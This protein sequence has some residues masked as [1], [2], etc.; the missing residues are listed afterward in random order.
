MK[1][2]S[3]TSLGLVCAMACIL[4]TSPAHAGF[5]D[6][7]LSILKPL[8]DRDWVGHY[9]GS[10]DSNLTHMIHWEMI[11]DGKA[12]KKTKSVPDADFVGETFF[13][14]DESKGAVAFLSLNNRG[15]VSWGVLGESL[16]RVVEHGIHVVKGDT[17]E[18]KISF[19]VLPD[20]RLRDVFE[21]MVDGSWRQGHVIEYEAQRR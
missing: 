15:R 7:H 3:P 10:A 13:Y 9:V 14:W 19:E 6:H 12:V 16:G 2:A 8:I 20:G 4:A 5:L 1:T 11:L 17:T 18:Y 21:R